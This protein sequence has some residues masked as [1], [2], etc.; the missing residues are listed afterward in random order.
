MI[1]ERIIEKKLLNQGYSIIAGVDEAGRGPLAGPVVAAAC[2]I[3]FHVQIGGIDD[4]KKINATKRAQLFE[5]LTNHPEIIYSTSIIDAGEID[6]INILQ[7]TLKAMAEC[8]EKLAHQPDYVLV[9]G[10]KAPP[11]CHPVQTVI[12]G[13]SLCYSIAAASIIAKQTRDLIM[14]DYDTQWPLYSFKLHKGYG[15]QKHLAA[16]AEHG[17]CPIHRKSFAPLKNNLLR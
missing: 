12:K 16:I 15:T 4:S 9:D 13:D 1:Q 7:A 10:N 8:I 2:I 5:I 14:D 3:P 6:Q 17:A 11:L